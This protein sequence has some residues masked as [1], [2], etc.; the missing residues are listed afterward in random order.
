MTSSFQCL[1]RRGVYGAIF[2]LSIFRA[3]TCPG[4]EVVSIHKF[5]ILLVVVLITMKPKNERTAEFT[6]L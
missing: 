4:A 5:M 2:F 1:V 3:K 6:D